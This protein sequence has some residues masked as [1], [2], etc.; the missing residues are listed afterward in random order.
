MRKIGRW[1]LYFDSSFETAVRSRRFFAILFPSRESRISTGE[2][3]RVVRCRRISR[4]LQAGQ[5]TRNHADLFVQAKRPISS[6]TAEEL[7][8]GLERKGCGAVDILRALLVL[9]DVADVD[10]RADGEFALGEST[11]GDGD[12]NLFAL[13]KKL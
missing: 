8:E 13:A 4:H 10:L 6:G 3:A 1:N 12:C 2:A 5:R 11:K 9:L 7:G